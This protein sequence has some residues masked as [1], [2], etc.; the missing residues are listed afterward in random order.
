[1]ADEFTGPATKLGESDIATA[2]EALGVEVAAVKAVIDVESRG[3]FLADGR[4]KILFERHLFS[5]FTGKKF[6]KPPNDDIANPSAGG[7]K[8]GAA[9]YGRLARAIA[10]DR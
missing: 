5:R 10:L 6:D 2:A 9:E 3:G 8:G 4:P 7:Y 1:M